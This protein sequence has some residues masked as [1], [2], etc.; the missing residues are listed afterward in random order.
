MT[1]GQAGHSPSVKVKICGITNPQDAKAAVEAGADALG[2]VFHRESP[3]ATTTE[4]LTVGPPM[5]SSSTVRTGSK[6]RKSLRASLQESFLVLAKRSH[7]TAIQYWSLLCLMT[8]ADSRPVQ[9]TFSRKI[10]REH[11]PS[12]RNC[13]P[14]SSILVNLPDMGSRSMVTERLL[15]ESPMAISE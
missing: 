3:G 8:R 5:Y 13:Y 15:R 7:S 14:I 12:N 6:S 11:G 9:H 2:F 4:T 1:Q 10:F